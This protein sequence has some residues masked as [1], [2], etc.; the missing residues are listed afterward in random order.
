MGERIRLGRHG[1]YRHRLDKNS[2]HTDSPRSFHGDYLC[3]YRPH[4]TIPTHPNLPKQAHSTTSPS[5]PHTTQQPKAPFSTP[6]EKS[7]AVKNHAPPSYWAFPFIQSF[8]IHL[9][10][11]LLTTWGGGLDSARI[12]P[13]GYYCKRPTTVEN[14]GLLIAHV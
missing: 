12:V 3:K 7:Y 10:Q 9:T 4:T 14:P 11:N 13:S 8:L 6:C 5:S 2:Q 1:K